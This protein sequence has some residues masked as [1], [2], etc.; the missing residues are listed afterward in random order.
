[1]SVSGWRG[2]EDGA[3]LARLKIPR[4][5]NAQ[6]DDEDGAR[7]FGQ[8]GSFKNVNSHLEEEFRLTFITDWKILKKLK[9]V[10]KAA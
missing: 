1:M 9:Y 4:L 2:F 7:L 3:G 5:D 6:D 8:N 10:K